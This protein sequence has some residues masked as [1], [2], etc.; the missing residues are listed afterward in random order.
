MNNIC[1]IYY[2]FCCQLSQQQQKQKYFFNNK[3][4]KNETAVCLTLKLYIYVYIYTSLLYMLDLSVAFS[5]TVIYQSG[6]GRHDA[7]YTKNLN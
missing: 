6:G 3:H 4:T 5:S 7:V 2:T 1:F